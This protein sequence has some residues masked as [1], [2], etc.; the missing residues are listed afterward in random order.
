MKAT[1]I[2]NEELS[3]FV[4][5]KFWYTAFELEQVVIWLLK[6]KPGVRITKALVKEWIDHG[7]Y[8]GGSDSFI[9]WNHD[10]DIEEHG[11]K[12]KEISKKLFPTFYKKQS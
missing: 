6:S 3:A 7:F 8:M 2:K 11:T 5:V 4:K 9:N 12:A 10:E 1:H